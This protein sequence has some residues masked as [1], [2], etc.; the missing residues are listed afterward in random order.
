MAAANVGYTVGM[1]WDRSQAQAARRAMTQRFV[2]SAA[3]AN[4]SFTSALSNQVNGNVKLAAAAALGLRS[5]ASMNQLTE[6]NLLAAASQSLPPA[7]TG[8]RIILDISV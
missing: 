2:D 1:A 8:A 3:L 7:S 6:I 5:A 4:E